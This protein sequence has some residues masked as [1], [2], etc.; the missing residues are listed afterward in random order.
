M[1]KR[2]HLN[3]YTPSSDGAKGKYNYTGDYFTPVLHGKSLR[4]LKIGLLMQCLIQLT[5]LY[6][7]GR[8]DPEGLRTLYVM[9]F[10]LGLLFFM[11]RAFLAA[12]GFFSW[13]ERMTQNQYEGSWLR[14]R[15]SQVGIVI[16]CGLL[17]LSDLVM[18]LLGSPITKESTLLALSLPVIAFSALC[19][20]FFVVKNVSCSNAAVSL[21][22]EK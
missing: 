6:I 17:A 21:T 2:K 19:L 8:S 3:L 13:E 12:L 7:I 5:L 10:F 22:S 16:T 20:C 11:G 1:A 14:F 4:R 15:H 18:V 9:P